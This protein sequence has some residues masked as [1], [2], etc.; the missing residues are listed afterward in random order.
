MN[1]NSGSV[2]AFDKAEKRRK[3]FLEAVADGNTVA[4]A[5][6]IAN[7]SD[8]AYRQWRRR[9]PRFAAQADSVRAA[10]REIK[11][12]PIVK[13]S[14][15][16]FAQFRKRYFGFDSPPFQLEVIDELQRMAAGSILLVLFAPLHG[17]TTLFEDYACY[18]L[19]YDK[20]W[21]GTVG[22]NKLDHAKKVLGRIKARME[23][24]GGFSKFIAEQGPFRETGPG[25]RKQIWSAGYFNVKGKPGGSDRDYSMQAVGATSS[26]A[27]IRTK[28]LHGDDLQDTN[29]AGQTE[30]LETK[31]R[32]DWLSRPADEGKTTVF[33][34]RV[35][36]DDLYQRLID[37][38]ELRQ[39]RSN[40][41]PPL[42]RVIQ[43]PA[44]M[45]NDKGE[46][47]PLWPGRWSL[48]ALED[49]MFKVK[50]PAWSRNWLQRPDLVRKNRHFV[51]ED[52][53]P[54]LNGERRLEPIPGGI[55]WIGLDPALGGRN[56]V[57][58]ADVATGKI[59]VTGI[60]ETEGLEQNEQI[61]DELEAEVVRQKLHGALVA[62]VIIES[63]NFQLGMARD[64]RL[65]SMAR[66]HGFEIYEHLTGINK[67]D[68]DIG[69]L[70]MLFTMK[71][72]EFDFPWGDDATTREMTTQ[73]RNQFY[74]YRTSADEMIGNRKF[75]G[76]VLRQDMVMALWF[77]WIH[78]RMNHKVSAEDLP[79]WHTDARDFGLSPRQPSLIIP[80][81]A[82]L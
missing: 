23:P 60:R 52:I 38:E 61:F 49:Q 53:N 13:N 1:H 75:R 25:A 77:I 26:L 76:N 27:S 36:D 80:V 16:G 69:I 55:C 19:S 82:Q 58:A 74:A 10:T 32:Q 64:E 79:G 30:E 28:H 37:D 9:Y 35:I 39:P 3:I 5:C 59:R 68:A 57:L 66:S 33:G 21:M 41:R 4:Q 72:R 54:C 34:N 31:F 71:Q 14:V 50:E 45:K 8:S 17:K 11:G 62:R 81:G 48:E 67:W 51:A 63:K 43:Y 46:D 29:S 24:D 22:M 18:E 40:G 2:V 7:V 78:W 6:T 12:D 73:L 56:C 20:S 65:H 70:S 42:L 44:V 15:M 47:V